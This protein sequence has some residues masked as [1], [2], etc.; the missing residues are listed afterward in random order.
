MVLAPIL[1]DHFDVFVI[2]DILREDHDVKV[3]ES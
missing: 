1:M 2:K 3:I